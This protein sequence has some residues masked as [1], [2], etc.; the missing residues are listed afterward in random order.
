MFKRLTLA[1]IL[2]A[3]L[4]SAQRGGGGGGGGMGEGGGGAEGGFG[5]GGGGGGGMRM[6]P[7]PTKLEMFADKLKLSKE[8]RD[9]LVKFLTTGRE[10][11]APIRQQME[12][13]RI[14]I[15]IAI[16]EGKNDEAKKLLDTYATLAAKM[17]DVEAKVFAQVV[18][19][20]KPNQTSKAGQTFEYLAGFFDPA[21][22]GRGMGRGGNRGGSGGGRK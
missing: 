1:V 22:G 18:A 3:A 8:Q 7:K 13:A 17:I 15:T 14:D 21:G 5:G 2:S 20:L 6:A 11:A 10:E 16:T 9:D 19:T 12:K 4:A